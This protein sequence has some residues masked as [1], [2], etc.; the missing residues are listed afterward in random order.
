MAGL[1]RILI[2]QHVRNDLG[3]ALGGHQ[4][5]ASGGDAD[6]SGLLVHGVEGAELGNLVA[7]D[8]LRGQHTKQDCS[9]IAAVHTY[10][11]SNNPASVAMQHMS[12][13]IRM[14]AADSVLVCTCQSW[15]CVLHE[16]VTCMVNPVQVQPGAPPSC[17]GIHHGRIYDEQCAL[18]SK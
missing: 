13:G 8:V 15:D 5:L 17:P 11:P 6:G 9:M 16:A 18:L 14:P 12:L 4:G 3:S 1:L 2:R 10:L 7:C